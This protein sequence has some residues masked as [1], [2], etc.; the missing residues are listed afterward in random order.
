V[1]RAAAGAAA[2][3]YALILY[4]AGGRHRRHGTRGTRKEQKSKTR[5]ST[6]LFRA[7]GALFSL[8]G[9]LTNPELCLAII[10]S[11]ELGV[12]LFIVVIANAVAEA[13]S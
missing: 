8:V 13:S 1:S 11:I 10:T 3:W 2:V 9:P 4:S 6:T 7:C 12:A 5:G